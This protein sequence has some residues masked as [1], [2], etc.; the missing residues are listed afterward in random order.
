MAEFLASQQYVLHNE[1][2][3]T[4]IDGDTYRGI[5]RRFFPKW[6]GW[7][8]IDDMKP[9]EQGELIKNAE[10]DGLVNAFY[11]ANF[12]D[13]LQGDA[14]DSQAIAT[15]CYDWYVNAGGNAIKNIQAVLGAPADGVFGS[16]SLAALNAANDLLPALHNKR[17][18]YYTAIGKGDNAKYLAGWQHRANDLYHT[19]C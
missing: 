9:L 8:M 2:G 12:W 17:I 19:L 7:Q 3:Y 11:K 6:V 13:K 4:P 14:I 18:A 15:Y 16:G 1:G 5:A 10:L